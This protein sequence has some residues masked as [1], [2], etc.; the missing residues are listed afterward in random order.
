MSLLVLARSHPLCRLLTKACILLAV[1]GV[2]GSCIPRDIVACERSGPHPPISTPTLIWEE[3]MEGDERVVITADK[4]A[5]PKKDM[6][7]IGNVTPSIFSW[8][9]SGGGSAANQKITEQPTREAPHPLRTNL[10][11]LKLRWRGL[12]ARQKNSGIILY[13]H[14]ALVLEFDPTGYVRVKPNCDSNDD[15]IATGTW[16]LE[17]AGVTF[18]IPFPVTETAITTHTTSGSDPSGEATLLVKQQHSFVMDFHINPFGPQPK[19]TRGVV[20]RENGKRWL[21]PVVATFTGTGIG[22]DTADL[23]YRK[24]KLPT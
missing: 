19:F 18:S 5:I 24:R 8:F 20:F 21:R 17:P 1:M 4:R 11:E 15:W 22:T 6:D 9:R 2:E 12:A 10:W 14:T 16:K 3:L 13:S 23:S 7:G